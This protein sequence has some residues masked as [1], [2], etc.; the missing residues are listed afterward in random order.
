MPILPVNRM[1][2]AP[3]VP[4]RRS[5]P[6]LTY[7]VQRL[8][9]RSRAEGATQRP[10]ERWP[11]RAR[12]ILTA[13][14]A[15]SL[16][17]QR[18]RVPRAARAETGVAARASAN[19]EGVARKAPIRESGIAD[20]RQVDARIRRTVHVVE[21]GVET[22]V[23]DADPRVAGSRSLCL[24]FGAAENRVL[25]I[26]VCVLRGGPIRSHECRSLVEGAGTDDRD[27][28]GID[29]HVPRTR[30]RLGEETNTGRSEHV[31]DAAL[32]GRHARSGSN[33]DAGGEEA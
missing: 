8:P 19:S 30:K 23:R 28:V 6:T 24:K 12:W 3:L 31:H 11:G 29:R 1:L 18:K 4:L 2:F 20:V 13:T 33:G 27:A 7:R 25:Q 17:V 5:V 14:R 9:C 10:P 26:D 16:C 21:I 32:D 22:G 15:A